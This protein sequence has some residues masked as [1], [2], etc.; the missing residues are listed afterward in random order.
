MSNNK[1]YVKLIKEKAIEF[2]NGI[3]RLP[4]HGSS[5][6]VKF[7]QS[8]DCEV[9]NCVRY[10]RHDLELGK[11]NTLWNITTVENFYNKFCKEVKEEPSKATSVISVNELKKSKPKLITNKGKFKIWKAENG[12]FYICDKHNYPT[13]KKV[14]FYK[15]YKDNPEMVYVQFEIGYPVG[16]L[17][18][19]KEGTEKYHESTS[20]HGYRVRDWYDT[21]EEA[22]KDYETQSI[23][24]YNIFGR[25]VHRE[26]KVIKKSVPNPNEAKIITQLPYF[27]LDDYL[28]TFSYHRDMLLVAKAG[29]SWFEIY[30]QKYGNE[31]SGSGVLNSMYFFEDIVKAYINYKQKGK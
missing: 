3:F 31:L 27:N 11:I 7:F 6:E 14:D 19:N 4:Y 18:V 21:L 23:K 28:E 26:F 30:N 24:F 5:V 22:K 17:N 13:K 20:C 2:T 8:R 29:Y 16:C 1:L 10:R 12:Y 15:A 25:D 9:S